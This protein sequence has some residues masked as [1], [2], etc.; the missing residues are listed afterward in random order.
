MARYCEGPICHELAVYMVRFR[1][2][3]LQEVRPSAP[4][5]RCALHAEELEA[6]G[7]LLKIWALLDREPRDQDP[8]E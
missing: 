2:P 3:V 5:P 8:A 7:K 6:A 4:E 1:E